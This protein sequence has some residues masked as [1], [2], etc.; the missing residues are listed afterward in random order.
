[1]DIKAFF[2]LYIKYLIEI[3]NRILEKIRNNKIFQ[4]KTFQAVFFY[5]L[6]IF[7]L[8]IIEL[9]IEKLV[10]KLFDIY[11]NYLKKIKILEE[12]KNQELERIKNSNDQIDKLLGDFLKNCD[13][14]D[15]LNNEN[16][17][18]IYEFITN[19][20]EFK[21]KNKILFPEESI[22]SCCGDEFKKEILKEENKKILEQIQEIF[23]KYDLQYGFDYQDE[24]KEKFNQGVT[25]FY[26]ESNSNDEK[27]EGS[28]YITDK[29][30]KYSD[31]IK[32]L[33]FIYSEE[34]NNQKFLKNQ[35]I[36][37][38]E[39]KILEENPGVNLN[40][41]DQIIFKSKKLVFQAIQDALN[42]ISKLSPQIKFLENELSKENDENKKNN[43]KNDIEKLKILKNIIQIKATYNSSLRKKETKKKIILYAIY[44]SWIV[45]SCKIAFFKLAAYFRNDKTLYDL[46]FLEFFNANIP[47]LNNS[48]FWFVVCVT[49]SLFFSMAS[50][51]LVKQQRIENG[52]KE[53]KIDRLDFTTS[54]ILN[55]LKDFA[56][57]VTISIMTHGKTSQK[58]FYKAALIAIFCSSFITFR[59]LLLKIDLFNPIGNE[60]EKE[61]ISKA[62]IKTNKEKQKEK[63][64]NNEK[65]Q[66][67]SGGKKS[68]EKFSKIFEI[69]SKLLYIIVIIF[70]SNNK[71]RIQID[72]IRFFFYFALLFVLSLIIGTFAF[73]AKKKF[74][75]WISRFEIL[76]FE[77]GLY[78]DRKFIDVFNNRNQML[79]ICLFDC[80]V[81]IICAM[82]LHKV[83]IKAFIFLS[84]LF[85]SDLFR[86]NIKEELIKNSNICQKE[87][88]KPEISFLKKGI[89][90]CLKILNLFTL[91]VVYT[92]F[93]HIN[94]QINTS[95]FEYHHESFKSLV[96][97]GL[98]LLGFFS[99]F[100]I[101]NN[102][103]DSS[104]Y[105][106]RCPCKQITATDKDDSIA[107]TLYLL[108]TEAIEEFDNR[109]LAP[110]TN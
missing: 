97:N 40:N 18:K 106:S 13:Q 62:V 16:N 100:L 29:N 24:F 66:S 105:G 92:I 58:N 46:S 70:C 63:N 22:V 104:L 53:E 49:S 44:L 79:F 101:I 64:Q 3:Y 65:Q 6:V 76:N 75:N 19:S 95:M 80:I 78:I 1:M 7:C 5:C 60:K 2:E 81:G 23:A 61:E 90:F 33:D 43:L 103:I 48:S 38:F 45:V 74:V 102:H 72:P 27:S 59:M 98:V 89:G 25:A 94:T 68:K 67:Y 15:F 20:I 39:R 8:Y 77:F 107:L 28:S 9:I 52:D 41:S 30:I 91:L 56:W 85:V 11:L 26:K 17:K 31:I 12:G 88:S 42:Q 86:K 37:F 71:N 10:G 57:A 21:L 51:A 35:I 83:S 110:N 82:I 99:L 32:L 69:F 4:N 47:L 84:E 73:I 96:I 108:K 109:I 36:K 87:D 54:F 34:D 55:I 14:E 50:T 93:F